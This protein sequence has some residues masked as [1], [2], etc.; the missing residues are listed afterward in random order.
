MEKEVFT[1]R[2]GIIFFFLISWPLVVATLKWKFSVVV[3]HT[4]KV[5]HTLSVMRAAWV[6]YAELFSRY[7][8]GKTRVASSD[9]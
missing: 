5:N 1:N 9:S 4:I 8:V 2:V 3:P 6:I 7:V